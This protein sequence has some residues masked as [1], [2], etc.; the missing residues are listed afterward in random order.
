V[1]NKLVVHHAESLRGAEL[2]VREV[3]AAAAS[4]QVPQG[5]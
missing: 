1:L 3:E 2:C 4:L 5:L